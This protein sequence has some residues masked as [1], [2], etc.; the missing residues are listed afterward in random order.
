MRK[1][2][3]TMYILSIAAVCQAQILKMDNGIT[4]NHLHGSDID[5]FKGTFNSY[6]G[7]VGIE[8]LERKYFYL[9]SGIGY[10]K[11]GGEAE[12]PI[13]YTEP[14]S[15]R[16]EWSYVHLNTTFRGRA[17]IN[18]TEVFAGI[19]PYLN[20]LAGDN[21]MKNALYSGYT[22]PGTNWGGR[23]EAGVNENAGRVKIGLYA[24]WLFP[25]SAT[26]KTQYTSWDARS[27]GIYASVGYRLK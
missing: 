17:N 18:K 10:V 27:I 9:S 8:Y 12:R 11:S 24:S 26:V 19:G 3:L 15:S 4:I 23:L 6:A 2:A 13:G 5:Q 7:Q 22:V 14:F 21:E 1:I 20:I 16:E 25:L